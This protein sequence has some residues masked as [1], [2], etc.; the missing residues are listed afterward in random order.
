M[1]QL[2]LPLG[3]LLAIFFALLLPAG[4]ILLSDYSGLKIL[5]FTIFLVSGYQT[6]SKGLS[7]DRKLLS[8]FLAAAAISLIVSP[9]LGLTLSRLIDLPLPLAMGLIIISAVPPTLSSGI[10]I[11][12]VSGGNALLALFLT[13]SL[14]LLGIFTMPFMLDFCLKAAGPVDINQTALLIK[15]L[16]LVLL[17][18]ALGKLTRNWS[19]KSKVSPSWSYVNSS[20]VILVVYASLSTSKSAFSGLGLMEFAMILLAV[21]L[22][23]LIL[24]AVNAQSAKML[25]LGPA[26]SKALI[27]VASQKTL[28]ISVAVLASIQF[29]TGSAIIV[30]LTF[31]FFQLFMDSFLASYLHKKAA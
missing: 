4:G 7:L 16:L 8:L 6:G 3:L 15:M 9:L 20:C 5:V 30:C 31:H 23:H 27:F 10:V 14:N 26:D 13:I 12:E 21:A 29:A 24:L 1:R 22:L 18:F 11:T 28:P 25:H 2:F 17:P 19:A